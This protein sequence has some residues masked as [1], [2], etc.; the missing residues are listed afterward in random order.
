[1]PDEVH[2]LDAELGEDVVDHRG[3]PGRVAGDVHAGAVVFE[4]D[5][6]VGRVAVGDEAHLL[7][8]VLL[9]RPGEAVDEHDRQ[10]H[11]V[12]ERR[13]RIDAVG[14]PDRFGRGRDG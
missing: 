9:G 4:R 6:A 1:M 13:Q 7:R 3:R 2:L 10:C 12:G 14:I 8:L 5:D 11:V